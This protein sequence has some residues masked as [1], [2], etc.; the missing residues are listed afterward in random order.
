[1]TRQEIYD[2]I[3]VLGTTSLEVFGGR[4]LGGYHLQQ[5]VVEL[6]GLLELLQNYEIKSLLEIGSA[7]GGLTRLLNE[8][9]GLERVTLV[10]NNSD[11]GAAGLRAENLKHIHR[12]E[13][14]N[15]SDA[16]VLLSKVDSLYKGATI[17]LLVIDANHSIPYPLKDFNNFSYLVR[18]GGLVVFHDSAWAE[19]VKEACSHIRAYHASKFKEVG[20]FHEGGIGLTCFERI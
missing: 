2:K 1:M 16:P 11:I 6:A 4:L 14:I 9:C 8:W 12:T 17:D 13:F 19:G 3:S 10:D 18:D 5:N 15:D 20:V 7:Q